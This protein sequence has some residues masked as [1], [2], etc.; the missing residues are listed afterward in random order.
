D[1]RL[2]VAAYRDCKQLVEPGGD[3]SFVNFEA[4]LPAIVEFLGVAG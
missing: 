2:A 3:H 1:Y 4:H